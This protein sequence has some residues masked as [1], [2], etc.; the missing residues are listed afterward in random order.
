MSL[1]TAG[2]ILTVDLGAVRRNYRAVREYLNG[3]EV[4]GV[5]KADAYGLGV[6]RVASSLWRE[7]CRTFFVATATEG[8]ELRRTLPDADIHVFDGIQPGDEAEFAQARILPVLNSLQQIELWRAHALS[9]G[10]PLPADIHLD[11]G[12]S[13]LGL[14]AAEQRRVLAR[15]DHLKGI[16]LDCVISHLAV[17]EAP[18]N[19]LNGKQRAA[20]GEIAHGLPG[21]RRS[22]ANSSG[23]FLG[24]EFHF[25]LAR[26][27]VALY[28]ANPTPGRPS[29]MVQVIRLQGRILQV[30]SVDAQRSVGYGAT[31]RVTRPSRIATVA[32]GY[33]DGYPL[34]MS[35]LGTAF[36][37]NHE[38]PVVG[39][40]S[41]DLTTVDV[42]DLPDGLA[43][44]GRLVDFIGPNKDVDAV[45]E[46]AKTI[47]YTILTGLG[48]RLHRI[49]LDE[50]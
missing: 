46:R 49:Y 42:T 1:A 16:A 36:L 41:M 38:I 6:G 2:A 47:P 10:R 33:A 43:V 34:A 28:G 13:R 31:H 35:N 4:A 3:A 18:M 8:F 20:F 50:D 29:P 24:P 19:P 40:V 26:V 44:P 39:R 30:R 17:A 9:R 5:V 48:R 11:T 45:A 22:L 7:G 32:L 23:V 15:P 27:G 21:R 14:D 37:D 25:D 12:M